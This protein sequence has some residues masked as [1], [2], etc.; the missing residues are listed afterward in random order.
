[1]GLNDD[2][3]PDETSQLREELSDVLKGADA[4]TLR[5][6]LDAANKK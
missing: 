5:R 6:L 2:G 4:A 3:K 1:M